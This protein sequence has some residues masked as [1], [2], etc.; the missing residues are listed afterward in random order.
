[1]LLTDPLQISHRHDSEQAW[2]LAAQDPTAELFAEAC[3]SCR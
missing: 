2:L 1:M 3:Q